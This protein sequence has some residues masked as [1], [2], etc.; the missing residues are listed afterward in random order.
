MSDQ[1]LISSALAGKTAAFNALVFRWQKR[2]YTFA[3][4]YTGSSETAQEIAQ[5]TF[6]RVYKNLPTLKEPERFSSWIYQ[7]TMNL[8]RDHHKK[9][10]H[11]TVS[12]DQWSEQTQT[13][14]LPPELRVKEQEIP[15]Q[16]MQLAET[17]GH[18][19]AALSELP[20]EQRTVIIMKHYQEL[21]FTEIAEILQESVNTV[22]S[23]MYYGLAALRKSLPASLL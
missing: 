18:I 8:C 9:K 14:S 11:R 6:I 3:Y 2:I 15:D 23:R 13:R 12:I 4:R 22:K 19:H 7:I 16:K 5:Q 20:E 10:T 21:K 17:V 1:E